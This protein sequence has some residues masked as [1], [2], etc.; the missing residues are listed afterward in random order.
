[1][2]GENDEEMDATVLVS[3]K[4]RELIGTQ[5][6]SCKWLCNLP[7]EILLR[8]L[9]FLSTRDAV[10]MSVLSKRWKHLSK[11]IP[12]L[13]FD[14]EDFFEKSRFLNFV[15]GAL[16]FRDLSPLK[17]FSLS[18]YVDN[19]ESRINTWVDAAIRRK[20]QELH[21]CLL[22]EIHSPVKYTLPCCI[23]RCET[24]VK[25]HLEML[26]N[27]RVPS[28]VCL[29]N[30]KVLTLE[31]VGFGDD[32]SFEKLLA[33]PSLEE[34][35]LKN[36]RGRQI[37]VLNIGAPN[38][39]KLTIVQYDFFPGLNRDCQVRIHGARIKSLHYS[40]HYG[41]GDHTISCPSS[42]VEAVITVFYPAEEIPD[43]C[44]DRV[45]KLLK[46]LSNV[47]HLTLFY[48]GLQDMNER[49]D[50]FDSFPVFRS[51]TQ[52]KLD[53]RPT[54]LDCRALQVMLSQSPC[55][56]SLVFAAGLIEDSG[57]DGWTL[58]PVPQCFLSSLKEIRICN[59]IADDHEL[60]AVRV[61]LRTAEVLEK[62]FIHCSRGYRKYFQGNLRKH[63][64]KLPRASDRCAILLDFRE[65]CSACSGEFDL[66]GLL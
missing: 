53:I 21:L 32:N 4:Y 14:E 8:V 27:F 60:L 51:L 15:E 45:F 29:P 41:G 66:F 39:L 16:S 62:L 23:F 5:D 11:S 59:F 44:A 63:L 40:G 10:R 28:L 58:D 42:L 56:R 65:E 52:L 22:V 18:C 17:A 47:E 1:M 25:F 19:D 6:L 30:L 12:S 37:K 38:L 2:M 50:L 55:L 9:D 13:I 49:Q 57:I 7:D 64:M 24:L 46:D 54:Y 43:Q 33:C 31:Y 48:E 61:L 35:S 26:H 34:L 20:V 36:C 3:S